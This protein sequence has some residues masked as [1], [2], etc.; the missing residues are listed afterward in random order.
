MIAAGHLGLLATASFLAAGN[1]LAFEKGDMV[2]VKEAADVRTPNGKVGS[3]LPGDYLTI[4]DINDKWLWVKLPDKDKTGWIDSAK[5]VLHAEAKDYFNDR[6]QKNPRDGAA[7][8]ARAS[9]LQASFE[10]DK[11]LGDYEQAVQLGQKSPQVYC[12][13]GIMRLF[14]EKIDEAL[15]DF[16]E[17]LRQDPNYVEVL[18]YRG[19]LWEEKGHYEKALADFRKAYQLEPNDSANSSELAMFLASCPD[20]KYRDGRQAIALATKACEQTKWEIGGHI[21]SLAAAHAETGDFKKAVGY[22]EKAL[23]LALDPEKADAKEQLALYKAGKP[24]RFKPAEN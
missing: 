16:N 17:A 18:G 1:L 21:L 3:V 12:D 8:L 6:I 4:D 19:A 14:N 2:I 20:A 9:M 13:R 22:G 15:A 23:E 7:Y 11:A 24:Y 5:V 10:W